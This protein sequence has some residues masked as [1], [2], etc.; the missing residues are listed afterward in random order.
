MKDLQWFIATDAAS[1]WEGEVLD[2]EVGGQPVMIV[3]L[4]GG[5][6]RAYQGMCPHQEIP[7]AAGV[8]D[9]ETSQL[10]CAGHAWV[11]DLRTGR[12]VNPAGFQL[13]AYPIR[14]IHGTIQ[15]GVSPGM[16]RH[17]NRGHVPTTG[18]LPDDWLPVDPPDQRA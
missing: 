4:L 13:F 18:E 9:P 1:L 8:F 14:E 11:F 15:V 7:M 12:G 3:H 10:T 6:L 16:H 2:V 5:D 17:Y